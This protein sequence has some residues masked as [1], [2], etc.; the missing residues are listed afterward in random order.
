VPDVAAIEG[1]PSTSLIGGPVCR[2]TGEPIVAPRSATPQAVARTVWRPLAVAGF[3]V[4]TTSA[5]WNAVPGAMPPVASDTDT[6]SEPPGATVGEIVFPTV[7]TIGAD[8]RNA[9]PSTVPLVAAT[10]TMR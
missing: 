1:N 7:A 3:V 2:G 9:S 4:L 6:T 5:I 10:E 8:A